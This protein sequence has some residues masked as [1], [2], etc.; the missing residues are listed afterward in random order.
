MNHL[1]MFHPQSTKQNP[2]PVKLKNEMQKTNLPVQSKTG[3]PTE[4]LN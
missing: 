4:P 3:E 1:G 2:D